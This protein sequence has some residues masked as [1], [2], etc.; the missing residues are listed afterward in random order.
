MITLINFQFYYNTFKTLELWIVMCA[1]ILLINE[2]Y[3]KEMQE[4]F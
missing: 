2:N 1:V 4:F 3:S